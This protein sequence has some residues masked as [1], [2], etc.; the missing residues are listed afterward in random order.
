MRRAPE[1]HVPAGGWRLA[2]GTQGLL[3]APAHSSVLP[4]FHRDPS[5][6]PCTWPASIPHPSTSLSAVSARVYPAVLVTPPRLPPS[7]LRR[8]PF[9]NPYASSASLP[10][11]TSS[12]GPPTP[13]PT[14]RLSLH[15]PACHPSLHRLT[16]HLFLPPSPPTRRPPSCPST[17]PL[18]IPPATYHLC[19]HPSPT[20]HP[21][22]RLPMLSFIPPP[23]TNNPSLH[24]LLGHPSVHPPTLHSS[25]PPSPS[26]PPPPSLP[27]SGT[28]LLS[29]HPIHLPTCHHH[30]T[31]LSSIPHPPTRPS[32]IHF[33]AFHLSTRPPVFFSRS[34]CTLP[35]PSSIPE[36]R[37]GPA[38][39]H[40]GSVDVCVSTRAG[41]TRSR[42]EPPATR[43]Y[44]LG[45]LCAAVS[46][47]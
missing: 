7:L 38:P 29:G 20:H 4:R 25:P 37:H 42:Q 32:S 18:P 13:P 5:T 30:P 44:V 22:L 41:L 17:W 36:A 19:L 11:Y 6:H 15:P 3:H 14:R 43:A 33:P 46:Q 9:L 47:T 27:P 1:E 28:Q 16:H 35:F 26:L 2:E 24:Q 10:T 23:P 39:V 12:V 31:H 45:L 40:P 8:H 21:L 34:S